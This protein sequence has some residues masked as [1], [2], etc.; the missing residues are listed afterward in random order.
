[1]QTTHS[2]KMYRSTA[3]GWMRQNR[4]MLT[5][6][7]HCQHKT[8]HH[9]YQNR[10]GPILE[11]N[12]PTKKTVNYAHNLCWKP[13]IPCSTHKCLLLVTQSYSTP[14]F[15]VWH[16]EI[17]TCIFICNTFT[18]TE[19]ARYGSQQTIQDMATLNLLARQRGFILKDVP[20]DGNA[21]LR[22]LRPKCRNVEPSVVIRLW[23]NNLWHT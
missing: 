10:V 18:Y 13:H 20:C 17:S 23:G 12:I 15:P 3:I 9:H 5:S 2:T 21:F 22:L 19:P 8:V 11:K 14:C 4:M 7:K 1:M 16:L 6:G